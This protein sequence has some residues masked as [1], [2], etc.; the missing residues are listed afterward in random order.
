MFVEIYW[1]HGAS[2]ATAGFA[3]VAAI[4]CL[5][6]WILVQGELPLGMAR[7][8]VLPRWLDR[9]NDRDVPVGILI[10]SSTLASI[11]VLCGASGS[12]TGLVKFMVNL[13]TAATIPL[14]IGVCASAL[15]LGIMRPV[16]AIGLLFSCGVL[17]GAG[18]DAITW[19]LVLV[20]CALPLDW[21][22]GSSAVERPALAEGEGG[23]A[24][25]NVSKRGSLAEQLPE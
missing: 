8:G 6:G 16:A 15:A 17:W 7:A 10:V 13:T 9:T 18:L 22:R 19:G 24:G 11:L 25:V 14:Y 1:G 23:A 12:T 21:M 3:A 4:G 2:L 20:L 5:N